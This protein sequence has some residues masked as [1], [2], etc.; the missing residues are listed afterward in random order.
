MNRTICLVW[1]FSRFTR[2]NWND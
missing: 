1:S 2:F